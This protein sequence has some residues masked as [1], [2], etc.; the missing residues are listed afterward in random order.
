MAFV[1]TGVF[2]AALNRKD[3]FHVY[4]KCL[5]EKAF[6]SFK[7]VYTSDYVLDECISVAWSR[8]KNA[9]LILQLDRIIQESE[10]TELLKIDEVAFSTAKS[11]LRK[12]PNLVATLTDWTSLV[13][14]N[15]NRIRIVLSFD[16]DFDRVKAL[17]EFSGITRVSRDVDL[18]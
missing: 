9:D 10:K 14:M 6:L 11:Y 13:L 5:L 17:P 3:K 15:N 12:Y 7:K 1:D 2:V 4:G 18:V 8:T 16:S